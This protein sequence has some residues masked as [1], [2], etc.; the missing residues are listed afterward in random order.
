[1]SLSHSSHRM[2][3]VFPDWVGNSPLLRGSNPLTVLDIYGIIN[4][5]SCNFSAGSRSQ[6]DRATAFNLE[7]L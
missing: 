2:G 7:P 5:M 1:M 4:F 3:S 6:L